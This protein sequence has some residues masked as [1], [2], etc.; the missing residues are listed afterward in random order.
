M[1][2]GLT[3][4][5]LRRKPMKRSTRRRTLA[6]ITS[7][8]GTLLT[9]SIVGGIICN[10]NEATINDQ[11][12][13]ET[14]KIVTDDNASEDTLHYKTSYGDHTF[15]IE[16][17][18]KLRA[19]T[20]EQTKNE[21]REGAAL[22]YNENAAL[23]LKSEKKVT[24]LGHASVDPV[25]KSSSAG[26]KVNETSKDKINL[27]EA[28]EADGLSVN[29]DIWDALK[30]G[31]A[32]RGEM[33]QS[34]GG[35]SMAANGSAKGSEEN[36]AFYN[37]VTSKIGDYKDA[38][39]ITFAREGA[40]GTDMMMDDDDDE[41]GSQGKISSLALH[42]NETDLLKYAKSNFSKVIVLLNSPYQMEV[43]GIKEYADSILYIGQPG[44]TGFQGVADILTGKTNP[45]GRLAD[46]YAENSLSAPAV[47]NS[48]TRTPEYLNADAIDNTIGADENARWISFQAENI[49]LGYKYYETRYEDC[50]YDRNKANSTA[51]SKD[52]QAWDYAK[53][54][55]Y[56]FGY[57]LSYTTFEQTL[58]EVKVNDDDITVKVKVKNTGDVAGKDV[59]QVYSQTPYGDYE[60]TNKVEKASVQIVGFNKTKELKKG[61]EET[62]EVKIDKYLLA[63]YDEYKAKGYILSGGKNY[64][65]IGNDAHDALNNI[66][67]RKGG[68]KKDLID[69][70]GNKVTGNKDNAFEFSTVLDDS[71]YR[72]SSNG[73]VVTNQFADCD[74]N[75][76]IKDAGVYLSRSDWDN[77]YP[78]AQTTVTA[79]DEM[80][81][82]MGGDLYKTDANGKKLS[83]VKYG[84]K[85]NMTLVM[86]KD[87]DYTDSLW[88]TFIQ[89]LTLE[90]LATTTVESFACPALDS[91][92]QKNFAVGDGDDSIGGSFAANPD[93]DKD[94]T[95]S[96][97]Y[98][99]K[100][101]LTGTFNPELMAK[102]GE[103]MGEEAMFCGFMENYNV[104]AD[105]HR[106][107]FGGRNF[108]YMSEDSIMSYLA[109]VP[110]V[111]AME[112]KGTHAAPKHFCGNDQETHR[113]GVATFFNEQALR[114]G[115]LKAFE[116]SLRVAKAGGLMQSFER[117]GCV[118][119]SAKYNLNTQVLRNEWGF[120]GNVVTDATAGAKEGYKSHAVDVMAAGTQQFC[121]DGKAVAGTKVVE[122]I[123]AND[124]GELLLK[125][126][127][128]AKDWE[129]AISRTTII[130]GLSSKSRV[131]SITPTWKVALISIQSVLGVLTGLSV[132]GL[133]VTLVLETK[134]GGK[135]E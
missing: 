55:S 87:V 99:S 131:V 51:G 85:K 14:S 70:D 1:M 102:R 52:G 10:E 48:G 58:S 45:S 77:T 27:K 109:S 53:E 16:N 41:G 86:M 81:R 103:L 135:A 50:I 40:E 115:D 19:D 21:M 121:L 64:I 98:T 36:A 37:G 71:K 96:M 106:T 66:I 104:G 38:C 93:N 31:T 73:V 75:T 119:T 126:Q 128:A 110:E 62:V 132:I 80:I 88:D 29:S 11:L 46:T 94:K 20:I 89:Q 33:K 133:V 9:F 83:D 123:K 69:A 5:S 35:M 72:K 92:A 56:T 78:K 28:L 17:W 3:G 43:E 95:P 30:A 67:A 47:V 65:A 12:K 84:I 74:L 34:W 108:E 122:Y 15:S 116:G 79:T 129:Y 60:K 90:E 8:S 42:K 91:I 112:K 7:I 101:I 6:G 127:K 117:Q 105:L 25:Y 22:L 13:A 54:M 130:N 18:N 111:E 4:V 124:D 24:V 26:N 125:L 118:W 76:Y 107:P 57:G 68:Q 134:K 44:L 82:L 23:P 49:Y 39:I 114:E 63:S 100:P 113:E 2:L 61:E 32:K 97:T 120:I 59:V